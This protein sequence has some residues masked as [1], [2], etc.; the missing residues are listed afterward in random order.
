MLLNVEGVV[1]EALMCPGAFEMQGL[2]SELV[3]WQVGFFRGASGI[4]QLHGAQTFLRRAQG[5]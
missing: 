2:R 4:C 1:S 5:D 3:G